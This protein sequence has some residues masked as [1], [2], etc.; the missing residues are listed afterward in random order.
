MYREVVHFEW[1]RLFGFQSLTQE[2]W[3]PKSVTRIACLATW[4]Y[5]LGRRME[6]PV[7]EDRHRYTDIGVNVWYGWQ[8]STPSDSLVGRGGE[9]RARNS[10]VF[11]NF[12]ENL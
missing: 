3:D 5:R 8:Y 11:Y 2:L 7:V 12:G 1:L 6:S 4:R 9:G 10:T